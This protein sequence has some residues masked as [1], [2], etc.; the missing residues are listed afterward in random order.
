MRPLI[1]HAQHGA[2]AYI[3]GENE[4]AN[5]YPDGT[6]AGIEWLR[7]HLFAKAESGDMNEIDEDSTR[8][9]LDYAS[10][11]SRMLAAE[12]RHDLPVAEDVADAI[13]LAVEDW[14]HKCYAVSVAALESGILD[15][16]QNRHGKL[17]PAYGMYDG[18]LAAGRRE[19][20]RHGW[21]E[22]VEGHVVDPTRWVFTDEH[23]ALWAGN[24]EGYDLGAMRMKESFRQRLPPAPQGNTLRLGLNDPADLRRFDK[25][26]GHDGVS[27][28]GTITSHEFHWLVTCP[29]ETLGEDA[30]FLIR[31]ADRLGLA[32]LVP[33]DTRLWVDFSANG[34]DPLKLRARYPVVIEPR[35]AKQKT[36]SYSPL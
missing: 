15:E 8:V 34:Y 32:G 7:G 13:G 28:S 17:F 1:S 36:S 12:L 19:V 24:L 29:L 21:L 5:P 20:N 10:N 31:T 6:M 33:V 18:P 16:F 11:A 14:K 2:D 4:A 3:E 30:D 9:Y 35:R 22:S 23:P 26:L 25:L 27:R